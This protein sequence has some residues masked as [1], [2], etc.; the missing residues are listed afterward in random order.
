MAKK[1]MNDLERLTSVG[2]GRAEVEWHGNQCCAELVAPD[3]KDF[4][5][6]CLRA[7]H[8]QKTSV[9]VRARKLVAE[10]WARYVIRRRQARYVAGFVP[11]VPVPRKKRQLGTDLPA[12]PD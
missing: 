8:E 5:V 2:R 11:R 10:D 9:E 4:I 3:G 1:K 12:D 6:R 7:K